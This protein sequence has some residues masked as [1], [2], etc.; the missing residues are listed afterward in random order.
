MTKLNCSNLRVVELTDSISV[1]TEIDQIC[2]PA[3][4]SGFAGYPVNPRW[5][6][7]KFLAWR[8]GQQWRQAFQRGEMIVRVSDSMLV[9]VHTLNQDTDDLPSI[10]SEEHSLPA[11]RFERELIKT[12]ELTLV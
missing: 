9:S 4:R 1:F 3:L 11:F 10:Q 2:I 7:I 5:S 8:K 6:G 12:K